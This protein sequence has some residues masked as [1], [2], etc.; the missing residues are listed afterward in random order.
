MW[1]IWNEFENAMA[2]EAKLIS[3][4]ANR[5]WGD[6]VYYFSDPDGLIGA[7]AEKL[8]KHRSF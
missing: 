3:A 5:N 8:K 7:F 1:T 4:V 2:N 6:R